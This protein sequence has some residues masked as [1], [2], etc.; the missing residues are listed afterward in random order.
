[1]KDGNMIKKGST[2]VVIFDLNHIIK[3]YHVFPLYLYKIVLEEIVNFEL[4]LSWT[5]MPSVYEKCL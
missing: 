1:M 4:K 3:L 5:E 2:N